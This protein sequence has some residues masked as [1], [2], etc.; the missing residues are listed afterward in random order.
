M[1]DIIK[2]IVL[3]IASLIVTTILNPILF[4]RGLILSHNRAEYI[5]KCAISWDQTWSAHAIYNEDITLSDACG[6]S[7][8]NGNKFCTW[9]CKKIL[10]PVFSEKNHCGEAYEQDETFH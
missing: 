8:K 1:K 9:F 4:I 10:N 3:L 5:R 2:A 6:R 7:V